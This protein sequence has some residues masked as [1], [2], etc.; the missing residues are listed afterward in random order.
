MRTATVAVLALALAPAALATPYRASFT[1]S[2]PL[3][4]KQYYLAQDHAFDAFP[5]ELP[6]VNPVR[7]AIIDSGITPSV[8]PSAE[9]APAATVPIM[10]TRP[11]P[12]TSE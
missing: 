11:P 7:V 6:V 2:D 12:E 8:Y 1:P 9:R 10:P 3:A 5:I 4:P